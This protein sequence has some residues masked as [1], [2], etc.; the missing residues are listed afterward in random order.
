MWKIPRMWQ[1][2]EC[3]IIGGGPSLLHQFNIP[4]E[5]IEAVYSGQATIDQYSPYLSSLHSRHVI[6]VNMAYRLGDWVEVVVFGDRGFYLKNRRDMARYPGVKIG[7]HPSFDKPLFQQEGVKTVPRDKRKPSGIS[8]RNGYVSWNNNSGAVAI[9]IA[10]HFGVKR[11]YLLGFD[12]DV[13]D[14]NQHWHNL[15][16]KNKS[17]KNGKPRKLPFTR[18]KKGFS[19]I[20]KDA[21]N[22]GVEIINCSPSSTIQEFKKMSVKE[23]LNESK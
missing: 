18:H 23:I 17:R 13:L 6:G 15:Y 20:K 9:N 19:T 4:K 3:W 11:I 12:M 22:L 21:D 8:S 16:G 2:G 14:G 5:L 10:I 7:C 1:G